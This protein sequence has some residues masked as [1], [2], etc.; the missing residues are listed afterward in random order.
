MAW[1]LR[2]S[3]TFGAALWVVLLMA[4]AYCMLSP[5]SLD[6][7]ARL[8]AAALS[9]PLHLLLVTALSLGFALIARRRR[10]RLAAG[11]FGVAAA[12]SAIMAL[13]PALVLWRLGRQLGAPVSLGSYLASAAR[14]NLGL[15]QPDRTVTYG[16]ASDGTE[17]FLDVWLSG[18]PKAGPLRAAIVLVHGGEWTHGQRS[19]SPDWNRWLNELGYEVFDV[20]YR[21]PPPARWLDEIGDVKSALGWVAAQAA[22]YHVDPARISIMGIGAGGNLALLA[23]F[24]VGNQGLPASTNV[25]PVP[26]RCVINLY[27]PTDLALLYVSSP[28]SVRSSIQQYVGGT[29]DASSERYRLLSP[30]VHVT[31]QAPPS[32]TLLGERDRVVSSDHGSVLDRFLSRAGVAHEMLL[33]PATEHGFDVNWGGF[34]TQIARQRILRFLRQYG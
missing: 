6:G 26:I 13:A 14:R 34:A 10:A 20:E 17:L 2:R 1:P 29:L 24:S 12:L 8:A 27:G 22:Q 33:L 11:M 9:Y 4:L 16:F 7:A 28:S 3:F 23:A 31:A 18:R 21:L 25:P 30:V 19:M 32:L 5:V 15:A